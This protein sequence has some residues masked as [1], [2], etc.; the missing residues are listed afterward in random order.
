MAQHDFVLSRQEEN[1]IRLIRSM[2]KGALHIIIKDYLPIRAE[3]I[4]VRR[5][6][7]NRIHIVMKNGRPAR[8]ERI[9]GKV[10]LISKG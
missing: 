6:E 3:K 2:E 7:P 4:T 10:R 9:P 5:P 8:A 1:L